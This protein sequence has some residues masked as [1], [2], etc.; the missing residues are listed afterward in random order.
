MFTHIFINR[1]KCLIRDKQTIFWTLLFPLFLATA[2][3]M[4]FG[5]LN[6]A[7]D[8]KTIDVAVVDDVGY[9]QNT[10]FKSALSET[11]KGDD[12]L[13]NLTVTSKEDAEKLLRDNFIKGYILVESPIKLVVNQSGL[14]QNIINYFYSLIAMACFYGGFFGSREITDIQANLSACAARINVAPVHKLKTFLYSA[15]ASILIQFTEMLILMLYLYFALHVDFGTKTGYILLTVFIGS[16]AGVSF[17]AFISALV[18][19]NESLKIAILVGVTMLGSF[20][21][22][23]MFGDMKYIVAK[24]VPI[25]SYLNPVNLLTD[26]FYS[27]YY[28]DTMTRYTLNM[29]ILCILTVVFCAMTYFSIRRKKYASL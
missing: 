21:S 12:K 26:S 27:L 14:S 17:G 8:F 25:V 5:N 16:V 4:A 28:Y 6:K 7:E 23:M 13:F 29:V 10:T 20:L 2:F 22:G 3:N 24:N 9:Q 11:S 15:S 1:L 19:K 18:K